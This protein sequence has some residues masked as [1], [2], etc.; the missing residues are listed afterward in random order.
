MTERKLPHSLETE[1]SLLGAI[2]VD[3][4]AASSAFQLLSAD[5]FYSPRHAKIFA[6]IVE[7]YDR[8]STVDE[9][10]LQNELER[11]GEA[12][13]V[14]GLEYLEELIQ[15]LPAAANAEYY[16]RIIQ[17]KAI[18]RALVS[19]CTRTVED[20][21]ESESPAKAQLDRAEQ[22]IFEIGRRGAGRG[23]LQISQI[24]EEQISRLDD[25][26]G[27]ADARTVMSG[28][29]DLDEK[30][31]GFHPSELIVVA[32]RP[33]MG[34]TS[35]SMNVVEHAAMAGKTVA[36]FT[37]E[38]SKDQL[39]QNL[40][41]SF[42]RVDSQHVR[43]KSLSK[44]EWRDLIHGANRLRESKIFV[45]DTPGLSPLG[46]KARARRLNSRQRLDLIVVDYLQ[47]MEGPSSESRQQEITVISR[48]L[49]QLARE[50][51]VPLLAISQLSRGVE[52]RDD[53]R[54]RM[55]DLRESGAIEQDADV[56]LLLYRHEY[57]HEE[58]EEARG[59]AEVII[60]KQRNGPT[61]TVQLA[62][63]NSFMRFENL[64]VHAQG[65]F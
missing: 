52:R 59:K 60:A 48:N 11:R 41:C 49:K 16:A 6:A 4:E 12:E 5:D 32:G 19:A 37:L 40:L 27:D 24:I 54:P 15:R 2:L 44:G 14:G 39:V 53:R 20:V 35:F 45:D 38:V 28:F 58:D 57:Y 61:G 22:A 47:L 42:S 17:D 62:F 7:V 25:P 46:L 56:V 50:L 18:L 64:A 31:N 33:S 34:K 3:C 1:Q 13:D 29:V 9:I 21:Y 43:K 23:F 36:V 26:S 55:S 51:E 10:L 63:L 30:T 8:N 65:E